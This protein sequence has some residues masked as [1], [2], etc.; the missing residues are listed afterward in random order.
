MDTSLID[1]DI[2]PTY[3]RCNIKG[4]ITQLRLPEEI[5]ICESSVKR[6]KQT[7]ALLLHMPFSNKNTNRIS[8]Y[9]TYEDNKYIKNEKK[10]E[11]NKENEK[12]YIKNENIC[13]NIVNKEEILDIS[14]IPPL[15]KC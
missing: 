8:T 13:L 3:V 2:N 5:V 12:K 6:S 7:G 1:V 15:E 14:E 11:N 10:Y 9:N 4:K